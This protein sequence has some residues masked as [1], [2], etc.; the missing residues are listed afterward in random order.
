[1]SPIKL[2]VYSDYL[3]PWCYNATVRLRRL[4]DELG[5]RLELDWQ[6]YLLRPAPSP[7]RTLESFREYTRSWLRPA[8]E[9]DAASFRVWA[10]DRGP[11]T[12]S[13]PPH[14][15]A[16][17]AATLGQDAFHGVHDGLLRAYFAESRDITD[18]ET[19]R[20]VWL[21]C[22]LPESELGR[23]ADPVHRETVLAEHAAAERLGVSGVPAARLDGNEAFVVGALPLESYRRWILR[24]VEDREENR[25]R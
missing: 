19:L 12:H 16:K 7:G 13:I 25:A 20:E 5:D 6:S 8:G 14:V 21:E 24:Q 10:S 22:G 4:E 9:P 3:C 17:A 15:L 1:V 23:A 2:I 11:P 18:P